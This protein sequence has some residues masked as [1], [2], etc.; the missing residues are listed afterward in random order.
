MR[1]RYETFFKYTI[2]YVILL[3]STLFGILYIIQVDLSQ[4]IERSYQSQIDDNIAS[5]EEVFTEQIISLDM[6]RAQIA[7]TMVLNEGLY[8][9]AYA[10]VAVIDEID[11]LLL[12]HDFISDIVCFDQNTQA[13]TSRLW[14]VSIQNQNIRFHNA[15]GSE[16]FVTKEQLQSTDT[17]FF[18]VTNAS[19]DSELVY[20]PNVK[21][22]AISI[23]FILNQNMIRSLFKGTLL[24][25][26]INIE[27]TTDENLNLFSLEPLENIIDIDNIS[28]M[29]YP[30]KMHNLYFKVSQ[31]IKFTDSMVFA[32][33]IRP[34]IVL[35]A[36][37]MIGC[38]CFFLFI[39]A[40]YIPLKHFAKDV[41][42]KTQHS[43]TGIDITNLNTIGSLVHEIHDV[44]TQLSVQLQKYRLNIQKSILST[45]TLENSDAIFTE[46]DIDY[47]FQPDL[48]R[49]CYIVYFSFNRNFHFDDF[50]LQLSNAIE[51]FHSSMFILEHDEEIV[52]ILFSCDTRHFYDKE[53]V[54]SFLQVTCKSFDCDFYCSSSSDSLID[55]SRLYEEAMRASL[56]PLEENPNTSYPYQL[57][58]TLQ[59]HL[60]SKN[61]LACKHSTEEVFTELSS[62]HYPDF[63][64]RLVLFDMVS[65]IFNHFSTLAIPYAKYSDVYDRALGL[66]RN[67]NITNQ[68]K[69]KTA[70]LCLIERLKELSETPELT[71]SVINDY[72]E[73]HCFESDFSIS[74]AS[75]YFHV[76]VSYFSNYFIKITG[77]KFVDYVWQMRYQKA[78]SYMEDVSLPTK[79]IA[80]LVGYQTYSGFARKFKDYTGVSPNEYRSELNKT[81]ER[82]G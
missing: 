2:F 17:S 16:F 35:F 4:T 55:F 71:F 41:F 72:M 30:S 49:L 68:T 27:L 36:I 8:N 69:I 51:P 53:A 14:H 3:F 24:P 34:Y 10:Q 60:I 29:T 1:Q 21:D 39:Q 48:N 66:C 43:A 62:T 44:N 19:G 57:I 65:A 82:D 78:V 59:S 77:L 75:E 7:T 76:S 18:T 58:D 73:Q 63:F 45:I 28:T 26:I 79:E 54:T 37:V 12:S 23:L 20:K 25:N 46:S 70:I 38:I 33:L 50:K 61:F 47:L 11:D 67:T 74:L 81:E 80:S 22:N 13:V 31:D 9:S 5:L 32:S 40:T 6:I 52:T 64:T 56:E 42:D 15:S